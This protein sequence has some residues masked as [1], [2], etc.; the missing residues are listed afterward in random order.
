[1]NSFSRIALCG[2]IA[3]YNSAPYPIRNLSSLL[4]NRIRLQGFIVTE[5]ASRWPMALAE[6][7]EHWAAGR[8]HY[9]ESVTEGLEKAPSALVGLLHGK[10][11][12]KQLVKLT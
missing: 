7:G 4:V 3:Q 6:L 8:I 9:R 12:G 5:L 2:M 11:L 10:N 1:M